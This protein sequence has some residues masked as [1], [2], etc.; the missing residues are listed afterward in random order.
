MDYGLIY[1]QAKTVAY[2]YGKALKKCPELWEQNQIAGI[3]WMKGFMRRHKNLSSANQKIRANE[4]LPASTG[5][6]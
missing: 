1:L 2:Q 3:K 5:I 4:E 6:M